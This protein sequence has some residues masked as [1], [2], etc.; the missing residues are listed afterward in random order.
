MLR[1]AILTKN[2][3]KFHNFALIT[4]LSEYE[5]TF[6]NKKKHRAFEE[7]KY[8]LLFACESHKSLSIFS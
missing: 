8:G 1:W 3:P 4:K 7:L 2:F 6:L 5:H